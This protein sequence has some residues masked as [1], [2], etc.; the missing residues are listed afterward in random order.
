MNE[1]FQAKNGLD[2]FRRAI[3]LSKKVIILKTTVAIAKGNI[4]DFLTKSLLKRVQPLT[5][6]VKGL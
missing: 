3:R 6:R 4:S 1:I 5:V 2:N